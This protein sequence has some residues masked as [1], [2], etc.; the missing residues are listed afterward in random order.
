MFINPLKKIDL[1]RAKRSSNKL[2]Q[3]KNQDE[4]MNNRIKV[5]ILVVAILFSFIGARL[6]QLQIFKNDEY[7]NK[8]EVAMAAKQT[9][10][11]PRGT[12]YDSKGNILVESVSSLTISYYPISNITSK[13]EWEMA[14]NLVDELGLKTKSITE[15]QLKDMYMLYKREIEDDHLESL[16]TKKDLNKI[17]AITDKVEQANKKEELIRSHINVDKF[18]DR[19]KAIY[20]VRMNMKY[21]QSNQYK[22]IAEDVTTKQFSY[23]SENN[24]RFPGFKCTFDWKRVIRDEAKDITGIL[25]TVSTNKQGVPREDQLTYLGKG[26]FLN[27][28]VGISGIEKQYEDYLTGQKKQYNIKT[29]EYGNTYMEESE[30][31]KSGY[32]LELTLDIEFQQK[33]DDI[34]RRK[35]EA[36]KN[37][38]YRKYFD[39]VFFV[40]MNPSNGDVYAMSGMAKD[41]KGNVVP[42]PAG[43]YQ[44]QSRVGSAVKIATVYMGMNEGV[45]TPN[46][47]IMDAPIKLKGTA[48]K[49]SYSNHGLIND[50]KALA[51]SSNVYMWHIAMRL[52]GTNYVEDGP[53]Y[54]KDGTFE[55][56][57]SYYNM[58]GLG[59]KTGIDLPDESVGSIGSDLED[60][61]I[62]DFVIGQ[63]DTYTAIQLAQYCS[64]I[65]NGGK[66]VQPHLLNKVTEVNNRDS[67][68][69]E[70]TTKILNTLL[71]D[72]KEFLDRAVQG[73]KG[74][75][76][77]GYCGRLDEEWASKTGTAENEVYIDG[78]GYNTT[79][80]TQ[81]AFK[82]KDG[83]EVVFSCVAPNSNNGFGGNLQNN[84]CSEILEEASKEFFKN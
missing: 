24:S 83:K 75:I 76:T 1:A 84:V 62:L 23:L 32:D 57:R 60:G 45:V 48:P 55:L 38:P 81:I 27:D 34:L 40:A 43:A 16:L 65:A 20:E 28:R 15:R 10:A 74:C 58:F 67:V 69:Y 70:Y 59:V 31:G 77:E 71:D 80:A 44:S 35:L 9:F 37:N 7:E 41:T 3:M 46:E 14:K 64:V 78:V 22:V 56:M 2:K 36:G 54:V 53:L 4:V 47:I 63:Y 6:V 5:T 73:M 11:S 51:V 18:D 52:A 66:R 33:V 26:Y 68:V 29:D 79:N 19:Q 42:Y 25:G 30:P 82:K 61:N 17:N 8:L 39:Q 49:S 12:I 13:K 21:G 50:I 72:N